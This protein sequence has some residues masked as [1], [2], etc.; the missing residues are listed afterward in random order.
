MSRRAR[1]LGMCL[2]VCVASQAR[3]EEPRAKVSTWSQEAIEGVAESSESPELRALRLAEH[4]LFGR[5]P[6]EA[7]EVYDPDCVYGVP[8]A[9]SSD[10]PPAFVERTGGGVEDLAFLKDLKLPSLPVR[11]DARVIDYL[12]FFKN[13]RRGREL[14][15]AWLKRME[16]YGPMIR[17][18]LREHSLPEDLQ[19]VA[20]VESGY[21][22]QAKSLA[23]ALGLWQFV[24]ASGTWYGLRVDR[25]VDERLDPERSTIAAARHLRDLYERFGSWDL[26]FA[27][28]NMGYGRLVQAIRKYNSNDYW[29]LSHLE[30]GMPF[31]TSIYVAKI[32]A[33]AIVANNPERF[34]FADLSREPTLASARIEVPEGTG[35]G[36]I[37]RAAG[38]D[39][40]VIKQYNPHLKKGKVPPGDPPVPVYVPRD[41][42]EK[43]AERW[44]KSHE[45]AQTVSYVTRFGETL[46]DVA[47]RHK[48]SAAKLRTL[49]EM[50]DK[51]VVRA[52]LPL[53]V[54][55]TA[56]VLAPAAD[57]PV[58][59]VPDKSFR[60][61]NRR[62][63][64]Y[65]VAAHDTPEAVA[66]FFDVTVDEIVAWN[67][68]SEQGVLQRDML[69]QL[70]VR[71]DLDLGKAVVLT[72]DQVRI[73]TVGS[74]EF[75]D[76]HETQR[77]RVRVRYR[78]QPSDT[79]PKLAERF[80]LSVGSLG[81]INQ[82][83]SNKELK[84][85]DWIIVYVPEKQIPELTRR[86]VIERV[87]ATSG[88]PPVKPAAKPAE[89][90][91]PAP[92]DP[93][94]PPEAEAAGDDEALGAPAEAAEDAEDAP[95]TA[96]DA[97]QSPK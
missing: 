75:F 82:F 61:D 85:D 38:V 69:L 22:P 81:R 1:L 5:G 40:E 95:A 93:S 14:A 13:D 72:P 39:V 64:F 59:T 70:F 20:M 56:E 54:P 94:L 19:I 43:F 46:E 53:L 3:A 74:D 8:D 76:F 57:Q 83:A 80:E 52:G 21:D 12:L 16:R 50:D 86:G 67:H 23:S 91:A 33:M 2:I 89:P 10:A 48:I 90:V 66:R 47:R 28:Y 71:P 79:L 84:A 44:N 29:L 18:V 11:W 31:E 24:K 58:V 26:T 68:V 6:D 51:E 65:R 35:L 88:T 49:N 87:G 55:A 36:Q 92:S 37:A 78:V 60:Y 42:Y 63:V 25:W 17:R 32:T 73:L 77:G 4:E 15:G 27:A 62:R 34:G 7:P 45:G 9:L 41:S 97:P 30:A 96:P